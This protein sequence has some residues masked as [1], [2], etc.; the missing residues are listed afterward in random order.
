MNTNRTLTIIIAGPTASGKT[1]FSIELAKLINGEVINADA[2]QLYNGFNILKAMP[3]KTEMNGITHHLFGSIDME[4]KISVADWL[5]YTEEKIFE[6]NLKKKVPILVGGSGMYI[7]SA[8]NGISNIPKIS[9]EVKS[10]VVNIFNQKGIDFV[11]EELKSSNQ[12]I[13]KI[14][15]NDKQRLIRAYE[16]FLQTGKHISWWQK[17]LTKKPI[18][19]KSYKILIFPKKSN[20][21]PQIDHRLKKMI[22][23]GLLREVKKHYSQNL[24]LGLPSMKAIGIKFF[25]EYLSGKRNLQDAISLTQQES[26]R[27]AKRQMTWFRNSFLYDTLYEKLFEDDK[28]F[29]LNVVKALNLL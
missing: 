3:S 12:S 5:K 25:F 24:S 9:N 8:L 19:K 7:N 10:K 23:I 1:S 4:K 2:M 6:I 18:I 17:N 27:Y 22:D 11:Y 20:L 14:Q 15:K 16:V 29:V 26:R 28:K 13:F 21:Y